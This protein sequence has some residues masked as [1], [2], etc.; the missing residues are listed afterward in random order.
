MTDQSTPINSTLTDAQIIEVATK[1]DQLIVDIGKEYQPNGIELSAIMLG[2][3]MVFTEHVGCYNTFHQMM[4]EISKMGSGD[5]QKTED[6]KQ[7]SP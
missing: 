3:L 7:E 1:I 6:L 2:R 5:L 4:T